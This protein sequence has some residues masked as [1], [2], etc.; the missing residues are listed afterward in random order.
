MAKKFGFFNSINGDRK[1]LASDIAEAF[2]IGITTGLKSEEGNLEVI[3]Y[4]NMQV[5]INIGSAMIFGHYYMN[6]EEEIITLDTA[7][8]ELNRI[9]RIV[10]RYDKYGRSINTIIIKG[11]PALTPVAPARLETTEQF[12]LVLAD[13]YIAKAAT[14]ITQNNITDMRES[15]LCGYVGVK[16]AVSNLE[17]QQEL[18]KKA[19]KGM[20][21]ADVLPLQNGWTGDFYIHKNDLGQVFVRAVINDIGTTDKGTIIAVLP[22]GYRPITP[23]MLVAYSGSTYPYRCY[24]GI[25]ISQA[26]VVMI[27][28]PISEEI[29]SKDIGLYLSSFFQTDF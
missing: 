11:T 4:Q 19:N 7:D 22:T 17:F 26:G 25:I 21:S 27:R 15:E 10:L 24:I 13:I 12:D 16:G 29:S 20:K 23:H 3:P 2:G 14:V 28:P 9:D 18:N 6:D 1:Y 8:G 5:Q